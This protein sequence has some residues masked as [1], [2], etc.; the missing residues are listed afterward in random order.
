[1][2][3]GPLPSAVGAPGANLSGPDEAL[4]FLGPCVLPP[5]GPE[6]R[7]AEKP[8]P[9]CPSSLSIIPSADGAKDSGLESIPMTP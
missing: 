7:T 1:M 2:R 8:P 9:R 4:I 6:P 3:T 5:P